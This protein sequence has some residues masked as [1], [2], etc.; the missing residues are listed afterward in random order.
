MIAYLVMW[1][2]C[3]FIVY[4]TYV[5][6]FLGRG[7]D[8]YVSRTERR[9]LLGSGVVMAILY[10]FAGPFGVLLAGCLSGFWRYGWRLK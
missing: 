1:V 6:E 5:A 8:V 10:G 7:P 2:V 4:G 9:L 3:G